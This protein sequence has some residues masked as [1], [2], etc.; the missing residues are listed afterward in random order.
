MGRFSTLLAGLALVLAG[1]GGDDP[2]ATTVEAGGERWRAIERSLPDTADP[3]SPNV[4][5]RGAPACIDAVSAEMSRRLDLLAAD[6]HHGAAFA[7]MYLRVTEA[8]G[9]TGA[10]Q[11]R[12]R[13]FLNHLDAVFARLYFQAFDTWRAGRRERVPEAW[14]I[15]FEAADERQVAG[16]GDMLLGMNAHISRDLP[17]A[18][19]STGLETPSGD[20]AQRDFDRVNSLLTTVQG[21]M[22]REAARRL[23]PTIATTTLPFE[24]E[25]SSTVG[26]LIA[27]WRTE[28]W[29]NAERL[30]GARRPGARARI[31]RRIETA[32]AGRARMLA[33]LTSN[34]VVGPGPE[35]RL[36]HC[37]ARRR[38][39]SI[40]SSAT[41]SASLTFSPPT[42][43]KPPSRPASAAAPA[44]VKTKRLYA[45]TS[46]GDAFCSNSCTALRRCSVVTRPISASEGRR[47]GSMAGGEETRSSKKSLAPC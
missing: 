29:D 25:A 14:R 36:R 11:F 44:T 23:D 18:L 20:S 45:S 46:S 13:R 37:E 26:E 19:L 9:I 47:S 21:P 40:S 27:R 15:A 33:A 10:A 34:L 12:D 22:I 6:C 41:R 35:S 38:D 42:P 3:R 32:A 24:R 39:A 4:C 43:R 2:P 17:F 30:I 7:L 8:V 1:C 31:A 5:G 16:I 28:A